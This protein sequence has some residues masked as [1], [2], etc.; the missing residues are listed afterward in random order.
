MK[1]VQYGVI[2][3]KS[4][5]YAIQADSAFKK[6]NISY[7]TIPTPREISRSCGLAIK[8]NLEDYDNIKGIIEKDGLNI[9][10]IYKF[11]KSAEGSK[12]EKLQ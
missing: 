12:V 1:E 8:F 2:T 7:R 3:F 6:G 11:L 5:H 9:E 4:T 10:A